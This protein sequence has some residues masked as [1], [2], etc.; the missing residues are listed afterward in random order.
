MK[1]HLFFWQK[2]TKKEKPKEKPKEQLL[3]PFERLCSAGA[4]RG[5]DAELDGAVLV[6]AVLHPSQRQDVRVGG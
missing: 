3:N 4:H 6:H 2:H 5:A 1:A